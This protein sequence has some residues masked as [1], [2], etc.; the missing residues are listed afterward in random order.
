[1][2]T[3]KLINELEYVENSL[4][5]GNDREGI[6]YTDA[7]SSEHEDLLFTDACEAPQ[8]RSKDDCD[9]IGD[10]AMTQGIHSAIVLYISTARNLILKIQAAYE[11]G[12]SLSAAT[13]FYDTNEEMILLREMDNYYLYDPLKRSSELYSEDY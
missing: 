6:S 4:I 13:D 1:M 7:L 9:T 10:K 5:F 3:E 8:D 12:M 11:N 2:Y